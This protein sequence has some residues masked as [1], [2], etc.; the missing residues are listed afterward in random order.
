MAGEAATCGRGDEEL[1]REELDHSRNPFRTVHE[2]SCAARGGGSARYSRVGV[3]VT[4]CMAVL[5]L[6]AMLVVVIHEGDK[7][8]GQEHEDERPGGRRRRVPGS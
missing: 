2:V 7:D 3:L 4:V 5:V 1:V 8:G 6:V